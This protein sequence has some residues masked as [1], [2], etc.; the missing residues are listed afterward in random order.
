MT[1]STRPAFRVGHAA[2]SDWKTAIEQA[3]K[4]LGDISAVGN[5]AADRSG[6]AAGTLG[7]MYLTD[8]FAPYAAD[9]LALVKTRTGIADWVGSVGIGVVATGTEYL[10]EPAVALLTCGLP[11]GAHTV[12]S[13][14][15]PLPKA[16][17]L[18]ASG[19]DAAWFAIVHADP[20]TPD[21]DE[22][23][24]DMAG[25]V[26]SGYLAG[27]LSSARGPT[28]QIAN[29]VISGGISGVVF[30][31]D[32]KVGT[33]LTQ[34][35]APMKNHHTITQTERNILVTLD[36]RPA[37][38][39]MLEDLGCDLKGLRGAARDTFIGLIVP[40]SETTG[41]GG[42]Y[43]VRNLVGIDP[44]NKLVAIGDMPET[45]G[46]MMFC[47]RDGETARGDLL[48]MIYDLK[49]DLTEPPKAALY[50]ACVGR[51]PNMFG[52]QGAEMRLI[53]EHLGDIP[54]VGF[55]ANGEIARD[56]LYG[57]TGVLTIFK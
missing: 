48:K 23:I 11:A 7:F 57:F 53:R 3:L 54:L 49:D 47:K 24:R 10:D 37:L 32:V 21:I 9:M 41:G 20:H 39:V 42:D 16:G 33:R 30:S 45:G 56:R 44:K 25:K 19:A 29:Q 28:L 55:F 18:T 43:L 8:A 2:H 38:D 13:G 22:L 52:E 15:A 12:F 35:C 27:G 6:Q 14:V 51:G 17:T 31:S 40:G 50:H 36:N 34:G 4:N 1:L 46:Q 5:A 26:S